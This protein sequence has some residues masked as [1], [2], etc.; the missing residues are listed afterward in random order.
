MTDK[1][2]DLIGAVSWGVLAIVMIPIATAITVFG[3]ITVDIIH[4]GGT[5]QYINKV[6]CENGQ[7]LCKPNDHNIDFL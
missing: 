6:R 5:K 2:N 3:V 1:K 4:E 7:A